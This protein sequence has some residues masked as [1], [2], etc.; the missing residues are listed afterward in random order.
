MGIKFLRSPAEALLGCDFI[1]TVT[2]TGQRPYILAVIEYATRPELGHGSRQ[3]VTDLDIRR[4]DRLGGIIHEYHR[5][6]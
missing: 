1:E 5:A 6:A 3:R 2:L 4:H